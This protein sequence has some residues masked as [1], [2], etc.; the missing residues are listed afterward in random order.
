MVVLITLWIA[1][2]ENNSFNKD[3][4]FKFVERQLAFGPRVP[5]FEAHNSTVFWI[6]D[7]INDNWDVEI[8]SGSIHGHKIRNIIAQNCNHGEFI[9]IGAHYDSRIYADADKN[10]DKWMTPVPGANDGASGVAVLLELSRVIPK[11]IEKNIWL[12][13]FDAEDQGNIPDWD[14]ILGS[15]YFVEN[16]TTSPDAVI[17]IDMIGDQDLKIYKE[18]NSDV[19]LTDEIWSV[20]DSLGYKSVFVPE[21]K[22]G[23][24]DDHIPFIEKGYP[25][26]DIIDFDYEYW[27]T[28]NDT[29]DKVSPDSLEIVGNTLLTWLMEH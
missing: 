19:N 8:Q 12:V 11:N 10:R 13:F 24:L 17:I 15:R 1:I 14:W 20:A 7:T 2:S 9:I 3:R 5:G 29:S 28:I 26:I 23:I 21:Y 27:H 6:I 25:S 16:L 18:Y 22:Y 4:A